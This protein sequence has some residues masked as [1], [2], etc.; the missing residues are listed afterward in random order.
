[1][2]VG[3]NNVRL[4][5]D[6]NMTML[7][8]LNISN[9]SGGAVSF[10]DIK[11]PEVLRVLIAHGMSS[12]PLGLTTEDTGKITSF[13]DWFV[14]NPTVRFVE[15]GQFPNLEDCNLEGTYASVDFAKNVHDDGEYGIS[16]LMLDDDDPNEI[17]PQS[18]MD[19]YLNNLH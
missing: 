9:T 10:V 14:N 19:D 6:M 4:Q 11:D 13:E 7:N 17:V 12:S 2:I 5:H 15:I 18:E 16:A 3:L 8:G 1:M